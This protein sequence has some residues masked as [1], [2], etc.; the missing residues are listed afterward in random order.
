MLREALAV[1]VRAPRVLAREL[2]EE[3]AAAAAVG[4]A[5]SGKPV[6]AGNPCPVKADWP[7]I[8]VPKHTEG[9][10]KRKKEREKIFK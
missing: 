2:L 1:L 9:K 3:K 10:E 5:P 6:E 7:S 4:P 8:E